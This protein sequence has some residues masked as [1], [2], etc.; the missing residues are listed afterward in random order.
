MVTSEVCEECSMFVCY[1]FRFYACIFVD[2]LQCS[3]RTL[4]CEIQSY[5]KDHYHH[6]YSN[7]TCLHWPG[8]T[9]ITTSTPHNKTCLHWPGTTT[10]TTSTTH[11]KT[12]LHWPGT[13]PSLLLTTK[14]AYTDL[15]PLHHYYSQ[16]NMPTLTWD[17]SITT[18]HNKTCLHWPGT[19][20]SLLLTTKHA[21]TDLGPLHHYY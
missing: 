5:R 10:I 18:T 17:H 14:H 6:Y 9:T 13:T 12:C 3:A 7:K 4:V 1:L 11:N 21:Y 2:L 15:G 19:T 20:P 8:T 16:Q